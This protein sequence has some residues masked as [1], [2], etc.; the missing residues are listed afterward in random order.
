MY[1]LKLQ[2]YSGPLDKLLGLIE[3]RKL[4]ITEISLAQVTDDFLK[5]LAE[6][7]E[8]SG[9]GTVGS[10]VSED[11]LRIIADFIVIAS[12]LIFIKSKSL[13]PSLELTDD[14]EHEI[15]DLEIRLKLYQ[16]L[17]P[18]MKIIAQLWSSGERSVS[19]PYFFATQA[20]ERGSVF[21]PGSGVEPAALGSALERI[22]ATFKELDL[23]RAVVKETILS[24][25]QKIANILERMRHIA[26]T[27]FRDLVGTASRADVIVT[28]LAILHLAREQR[29]ILAQD[30]TGADIVITK[31]PSQP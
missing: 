17:R 29:I 25:E 26:S 7:R 4:E 11:D 19:R 14:E 23:E 13:L 28:F 2:Q 30:D 9:G 3:E 5:Y 6:L 10:R 8:S 24:L 31:P 22:F 12:R 16:G 21:Y 18:A 27:S 15:R 1:E 20:A